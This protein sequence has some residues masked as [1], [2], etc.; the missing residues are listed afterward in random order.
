[1]KER[2]PAAHPQKVEGE[3][4]ADAWSARPPQMSLNTFEINT[5]R[6][7]DNYTPSS[8]WLRVEDLDAWRPPSARTTSRCQPTSGLQSQHPSFFL[9]RGD[10]MHARHSGLWKP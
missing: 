5:A 2:F 9:H 8:N 7:M 4:K 6:T 10:E 1:M 3:K